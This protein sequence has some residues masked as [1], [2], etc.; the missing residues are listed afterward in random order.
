MINVC[1]A[2]HPQRLTL[3]AVRNHQP[4]TPRDDPKSDAGSTSTIDLDRC[5]CATPVLQT[6]LRTVGRGEDSSPSQILV[7]RPCS[8]Q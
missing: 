1:P 8:S 6:V 4:R 2:D 3:T 5:Y 7:P